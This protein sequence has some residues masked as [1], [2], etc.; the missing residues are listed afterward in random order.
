[1]DSGFMVVPITD[2]NMGIYEKY[3]SLYALEDVKD[4]QHCVFGVSYSEAPCG[5]GAAALE[6]SETAVVTSLMV[7]PAFRRMGAGRSLVETLLAWAVSVGAKKLRARYALEGR[8]LISLDKCL[9]SCGFAPPRHLST[10]CGVDL[11]PHMAK[12]DSFPH[13]PEEYRVRFFSE[14]TE[15]QWNGV[16]ND[17]SIHTHDKV[18]RFLE[19]MDRER[20]LILLDKGDRAMAYVLLGETGVDERYML[21]ATYNAEEAPDESAFALLMTAALALVAGMEKPVLLI[22][23]VSGAELREIE[24]TFGSNIIMYITEH[25]T[26]TAL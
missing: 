14:L 6:D 22:P 15:S 24:E 4:G 1:M 11:R 12:R 10:I 20:S 7:D 19:D 2:E 25:E 3:L 5:A 8:E 9:V 13:V 21:L 26:Q 18:E 23:T 16:I 17:S